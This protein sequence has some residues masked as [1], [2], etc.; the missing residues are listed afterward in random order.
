MEVRS[1]QLLPFRSQRYEEVANS[2]DDDAGSE[3]GSEPVGVEWPAQRILA[4]QLSDGQER[5]ARG[6]EHQRLLRV[7]GRSRGKAILGRPGTY[8]SA[9]YHG[10][11]VYRGVMCCSCGRN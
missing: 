10:A 8:I 11:A 3:V 6:A 9:T 1:P 4:P 5:E 2:D 7:Q